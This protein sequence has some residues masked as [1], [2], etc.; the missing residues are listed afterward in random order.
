MILSQKLQWYY[1][2]KNDTINVKKKL[3]M[4]HV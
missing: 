4:L 1:K 3:C 2:G